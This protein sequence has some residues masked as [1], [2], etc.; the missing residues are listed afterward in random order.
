D[1]QR[2]G[3][4]LTESDSWQRRAI[5]TRRRADLTKSERSGS[6]SDDGERQQRR[7]R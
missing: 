3:K 5:E 1:E 2:R 4:A 6:D 7:R